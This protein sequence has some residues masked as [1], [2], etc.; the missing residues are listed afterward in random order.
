MKKIKVNVEGL[1]PTA[2]KSHSSYALILTDE[3]SHKKKLPI[4][5][6]PFEAQY[7]ALVLDDITTPRPLTHDLLKSV[8]EQLGATIE[9]VIISKLEKGVF[10]STI[11]LKINEKTINIDSRTSDAVALALKSKAPIYIYKHIFDANAIS[12]E[13]IKESENQAKNTPTDNEI[14]NL[15][16]INPEKLVERLYSLKLKSKQEKIIEI[17][18]TLSI[19][20]LK[21]MLDIAVSKEYYEVAAYIRDEINSR[22]N[23]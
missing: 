14:E 5:I 11:V 12:I 22:E 8:I 10:Y 13:E 2:L 7:I 19:S 15:E 4:I 17:V 16:K 6:G 18:K 1:T 3:T 21:E 23:K 9:E 20:K